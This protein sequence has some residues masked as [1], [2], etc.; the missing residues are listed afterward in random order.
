MFFYIAIFI[1]CVIAAII[2]P[3]LF[4]LISGAGKAVQRS[5]LPGAEKGPVSHLNISPVYAGNNGA[6]TP[7]DLVSYNES[8]ALARVRAKRL[9]AERNTAK[10]NSYIGPRNEYSAPLHTDVNLPVTGWINRE[11]KPSKDGTS[12][13]VTRRV[14][15]REKNPKHVNRPTSW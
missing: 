9:A 4:R 7:W 3:W 6:S 14:R 1:A 13:K 8:T 15:T 5:V 12:Y 10:N 11:D 2:I